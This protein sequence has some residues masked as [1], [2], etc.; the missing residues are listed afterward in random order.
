MSLALKQSLVQKIVER[1]ERD[2]ELLKNSA[3]AAAEAATHEESKAEDKYDTRGLEASYLAGA[4]ARRASDIQELI[5]SYRYLELREFAPEDSIAVSA[6]VEF[7]IRVAGVNGAKKQKAFL[8]PQGGGSLIELD[9]QKIQVITPVSS[10]GE[11][12]IG[13][14]QGDEFEYEAGAQTRECRIVSVS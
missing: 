4:Q 1:L 5:Q 10:L 8:V 2:L 14:S 7:E 9:G 3:L 12:L 6:L 13:R 11:E